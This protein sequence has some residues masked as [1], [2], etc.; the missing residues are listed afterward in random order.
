MHDH[1]V[2]GAKSLQSSPTLCNLQPAPQFIG[3]S[4]QEYWSGL[5]CHPPRD[6]PNPGFDPMSPAVP[7]SQADSLHMS[8]QGS[9]IVP[10]TE[11]SNWHSR[12]NPSSCMG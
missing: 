11:V 2:H 10:Q 7:A 6:L 8:H 3:F 12:A 4:R 1:T 5:P 9:L